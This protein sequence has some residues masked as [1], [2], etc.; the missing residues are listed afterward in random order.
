MKK[1]K[2]LLLLTAITTLLF[3]GCGKNENEL[4]MVTEAG[5]APYEYYKD[6]K[7]V[8]TYESFPAFQERAN[9]NGFTQMNEKE[10]SELSKIYENYFK[11]LK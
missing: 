5:F 9:G 1:L 2:I 7:V 6:G 11:K 8:G 3:T 10:K 4:V